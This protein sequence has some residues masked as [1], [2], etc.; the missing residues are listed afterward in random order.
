[1][2]EEDTKFR[3]KD[4]NGVEKEFYKLFTF[5][6]EETGKSYIAY[7][8]NSLDEKGNVIV[9]ANSYDPSGND[10]TLQPLQSEKEW[11]VIENILIATQEQIRKEMQESS[12]EDEESIRG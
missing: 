6:S 12:A 2:R 10:L 3:L 8:D 11:K 5:D 1:M 4:E 9:R 7:T